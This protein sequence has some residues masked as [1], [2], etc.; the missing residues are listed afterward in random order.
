MSRKA[1]SRKTLMIGLVLAAV[2]FVGC[3]QA[4]VAQE[5]PGAG[6]K[7]RPARATWKTGFFLEAVYSRGLQELGYHVGPPKQMSSPE[8]YEALVEKEVDFWANGWFP[9]HNSQLP[10]DFERRASL[11]GRVVENGAVQGYLVSKEHAARHDITSLEDFKRDD[12]KQAFD[13]NN[14]GKADMVACPD[15]WGCA[16]VIAH[17]M[18]AY[19]LEEHINLLTSGYTS[20]MKEALQRHSRGEPI[21]FY[22]WTPHWTVGKLEPGKDVVWINVPEIDP[23]PSQKGLG[24]AM[25]A[26]SLKGAVTSPIR[27]GY[28]INDIRIAANDEFLN[29]N[30]AAKRFF[31][32]MRIPLQDIARQNEKMYEGEDGQVAIERHAQEWIDNNRDF[33]EQCLEKARSNLGNMWSGR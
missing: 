22:T 7:V 18:E 29:N 28:A 5:K 31:K 27:L 19:G 17:H 16:E 26:D 15:G 14:D 33:W 10:S 30:P 8:F 3:Q 13:H 1:L 12:V 11:V 23:A 6:V 32:V 9:L 4:A 24:D 25:V 20:N 21:L 2:L